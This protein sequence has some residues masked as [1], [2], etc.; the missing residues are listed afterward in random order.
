M[1]M[2]VTPS[3]LALPQSPEA[4][5]ES[6]PLT[7]PGH[8]WPFATLQLPGLV[9][10]SHAWF[11]APHAVPTESAVAVQSPVVPESY[12]HT[13]HPC[14]VQC[15]L[16]AVQVA[17]PHEQLPLAHAAALVQLW[18]SACCGTQVEFEQ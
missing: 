5:P 10:P 13:G 15:I 1:Q 6:A 3:L 18:P 8:G 7:A 9:V 11:G 17:S 12:V 4:Q 14:S 2:S 16:A